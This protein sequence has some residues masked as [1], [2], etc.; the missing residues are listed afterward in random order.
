VN[1][2]R[3]SPRYHVSTPFEGV[4]QTL[5]GATI[6][7]CDG[8]CVLA[9]SDVPLRTG[10]SLVL[11][12]FAGSTRRTLPVTVVENVPVI[13][14]GLV[15]YRLRLATAASSDSLDPEGLLVIDTPVR[16]LDIS[17]SGFLLEAVRQ[18]AAGTVGLLQVAVDGRA[19]EG[20]VRVIRC[21]PIEG[22]AD[23]HRLG[24]EFLRLRR[25]P[26]GSAL[27]TAFL[28]MMHAG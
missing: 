3:R 8:A 23:R 6:E 13:Q 28:A 16:V 12:V 7:S 1:G 20:E 10:L 25:V 5:T 9:S 2:R 21:S 19:Y 11:D 17:E 26:Y 27:G 24:T 22:T 14:S 18:S 4:L 15:R